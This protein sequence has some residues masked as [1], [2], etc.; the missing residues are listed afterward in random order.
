M[1][2]S[3]ESKMSEYRVIPNEAAVDAAFMQKMLT[4]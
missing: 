4:R 2:K 1:A 3:F